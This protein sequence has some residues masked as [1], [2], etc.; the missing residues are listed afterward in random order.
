MALSMLKINEGPLTLSVLPWENHLMKN[1]NFHGVIQS[2]NG[3]LAG[4]NHGKI[5]SFLI[6]VFLIFLFYKMQQRY[7]NLILK[8]MFLKK[9]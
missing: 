9:S 1:K 5:L 4:I 8:N 7:F 2:I 3:V 6:N